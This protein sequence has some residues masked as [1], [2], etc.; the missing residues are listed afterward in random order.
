MFKYIQFVLSNI[1]AFFTR[2]FTKLVKTCFY[3]LVQYSM[4]EVKLF[5]VYYRSYIVCFYRVFSIVVI[6]HWAFVSS[7]ETS[8]RRNFVFYGWLAK[9]GRVK[10]SLF[11]HRAMR[12]ILSFKNRPYFRVFATAGRLAIILACSFAGDNRAFSR[13]RVSPL[14]L[15]EVM[16]SNLFS[17]ND[18][19]SFPK[20]HTNVYIFHPT[21]AYFITY[22]MT[23]FL[24]TKKSP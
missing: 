23:Y 11:S 3:W 21:K 22:V 8:D 17:F 9:I 10:M 6:L 14:L 24:P 16:C 7:S 1:I 4:A 18:R 15:G 20:L 5:N 19:R 2:K 13:E 12:R